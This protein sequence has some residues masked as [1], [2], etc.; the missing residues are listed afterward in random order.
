MVADSSKMA[1]EED[2]DLTGVMWSDRTWLTHFPLNEHTVMDYFSLSQF[3]DR[4]C[5]NELVKMQNL[6]PVLL[7]T[8]AGIEYKLTGTP[9]PGLFIITK[10][11]RSLNPASLEPL[12]NYYVHEGNVYQSPTLHSVLSTRIL[13]SLHHLRNAFN[14]MQSAAV[15]SAQG[16]CVWD[17]PPHA[18]DEEADKAVDAREVSSRAERSAVDRMLWDILEK[19]RRINA[20]YEEK[21]NPPA[22]RPPGE[23]DR[24]PAIQGPS[25]PPQTGS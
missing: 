11:R 25:Q 17:P 9:A 14:T 2:E 4:R 20:A 23:M 12:A 18:S 22:E 24:Q 5:N 16:K 15:L 21:N 3:Y 13:Q 8:M 19:N 6:D 1:T 10:S 7:Q